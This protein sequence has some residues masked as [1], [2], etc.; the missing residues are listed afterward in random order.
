MDRLFYIGSHPLQEKSVLSLILQKVLVFIS[1]VQVLA[2]LVCFFLEVCNSTP[3]VLHSQTIIPIQ[4]GLFFNYG[5]YTRGNKPNG[6]TLSINKRL[7]LIN[8]NKRS[9]GF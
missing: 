5:V 3:E 6:I 4:V 8:G 7:Y 1:H 2:C 9:G